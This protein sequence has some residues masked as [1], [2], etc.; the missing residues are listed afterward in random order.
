[1]YVKLLLLFKICLNKRN[2]DFLQKIFL[3]YLL[4]FLKNWYS[5]FSF[6]LIMEKK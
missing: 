5:F 3:K 1:M 4:Y 6:F 2:V